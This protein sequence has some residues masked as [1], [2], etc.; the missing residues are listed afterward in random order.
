[1]MRIL[2][3]NDDGIDS[4]GLW[5]AAEALSELGF[6]TVVAPREQASGTGRSKPNS[7][8][9]RVTPRKLTVHG[10]EWI[11]YA[12]GGTPAQVVQHAILEIMPECPDLVVSGINYGVNVGFG[13]TISG[14]V[15]A[16]MEAAA[17]GIPSLAVSL[18]TDVDHHLSYSREIDFSTSAYFTRY[19]AQRYL[20]S[21]LDAD[22]RLLKVDV[23]A[24]ATPETA[25]KITRLSRHPYY[26]PTSP[27]RETGD[28]SKQTDYT[29]VKD[30]SGFDEDSDVYAV[31]VEQVV[32]LTPLS[33]DLT[34]RVDF[35]ELASQLHHDKP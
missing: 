25:W 6:V 11:V 19:F 20:K 12:V 8:D 30:F 34:S 18:E 5:A 27:V 26:L 14:T 17:H 28:D 7:S 15:G 2:L 24:N 13:V 22:V 9:W 31:F 21:E 35:T 4:P 1:M 32:S 3:T 16:A 23:P 33:L 10:K 29:T